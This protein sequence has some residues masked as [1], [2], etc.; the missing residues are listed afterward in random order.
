MSPHAD[1]EEMGM[2]ERGTLGRIAGSVRLV[3]ANRELRRLALVWGLWICGEWAVLVILSVSAYERSGTGAVAVI[4]ATRTLPAALAGPLTSVLADRVRRSLVLAGALTTWCVLVAIVPLALRSSTLTWTY[5]VVAT[6]AVTS[7][8]LRPAVSGLVPQVVTRAEELAA[9]NSV[10]SLV[11]AAASLLGPL[12]GG[13]LLATVT[14]AHSYLVTAAV[15]AVAALLA[16]GIRTDFRP[17]EH[18]ARGWWS[19]LL[20][21]FAGFPALL[22]TTPLR[23][24]VAIFMAQSLTRGLLNVYV[25]AVAVSLLH[26]DVDSTGVLFSALG[27]GGLLGAFLTLAGPR[28][29]PA[30]A[31]AIGMSMWGLPLVLMAAVPHGWVVWLAIAG[32]GIGNA[33]ADVFGFTLMHRLIP[34]HTL[35]RAFGAFWGGAAACQA[36]GAVLATPLITHAHLRGALVITGCFMVL[37][38]AACWTALRGLEA[39]LAVDPERVDDLRRCGV[40]APL[41][42]LALEQLAR[43]SSPVDVVAGTTVMAQGDLGDTFFVIV[44]GE[45]SAWVGGREVRRMTRGDCFGEIAALRHTPRSATIVAE[46]GCRLLALEGQTFVLAVTGHT[47]ARGA[48]FGL[49]EQRLESDRRA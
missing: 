13:A 35:G 12:L 8:V 15:F 10:Y 30:A 7:T 20:E 2:R 1:R 48:A 16:I 34:D 22:A 41:T 43:D 40:L 6:A 18:A 23:A 21:P 45:L 33:V 17:P 3:I 31:F 47:P 44:D 36:L 32:I 11:E 28:W 38:T 37:V 27:A 9:A 19:R 5:V 4:A 49:S 39:R 24:V 46:S 42:T 26:Q 14:H 25:V 29:R